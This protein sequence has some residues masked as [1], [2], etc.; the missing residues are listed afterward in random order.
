MPG[1]TVLH[2]GQ[3]EAANQVFAPS[4]DDYSRAVAIIEAYSRAIPV[5]Q[6]GAV[7]PDEMIDEAS[8]KMAETIVARGNAAGLVPQTPALYP[9]KR[10]NGTINAIFSPERPNW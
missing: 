10:L 2:P 7:M 4:A 3:I 9:R 5:D 1:M 6:R 8:R